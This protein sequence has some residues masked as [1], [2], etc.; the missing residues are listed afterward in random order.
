MAL[1]IVNASF[2]FKGTFRRLDGYRFY[3]HFCRGLQERLP[4]A[5]P[6]PWPRDYVAGFDAVKR[7]T[8]R[9]ARR[10]ETWLSAEPDL[11][12]LQPQGAL[13]EAAGR[14]RNLLS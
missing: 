3:S 12:R 13:R 4:G 1:L 5:M 9:Y 8:R 11:V 2:G 7:D 10:Q 6:A 14:V